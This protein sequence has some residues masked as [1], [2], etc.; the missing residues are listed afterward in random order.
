[1]IIISVPYKKMRVSPERH[2]INSIIVFNILLFTSI[3]EDIVVSQT[4]VTSQ[5]V[6]MT[7]WSVHRRVWYALLPAKITKTSAKTIQR[8][9]ITYPGITLFSASK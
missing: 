4:L 1:M 8:V 6:F 5:S 9:L 7:R 2:G 3:Q